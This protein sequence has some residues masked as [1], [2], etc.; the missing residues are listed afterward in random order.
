MELDG[1]DLTAVLAGQSQAVREF[2]VGQCLGPDTGRQQY[3]VC[4]KQHKY[5][6]C[7]MNATEELYDL[8]DDPNEL[9]N[10]VGD[11]PNVA[12]ELRNQES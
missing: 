2:F 12:R 11:R 6:Y 1:Q 3:M 7:E 9:H 8:E 4:T 10:R 5:I